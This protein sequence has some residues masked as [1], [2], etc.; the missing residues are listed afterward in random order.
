[1][2]GVDP[3][4]TD[5]STI[6][7]DQPLRDPLVELAFDV[8]PTPNPK[9]KGNCKYNG[10][11]YQFIPGRGVFIT[12]VHQSTG[13]KNKLQSNF[14]AYWDPFET[15]FIDGLGCNKC[16]D[17]VGTLQINKR[18]LL[19]ENPYYGGGN[20]PS[21]E[22]LLEVLPTLAEL[23]VNYTDWSQDGP[24]P[25]QGGPGTGSDAIGKTIDPTNM[26]SLP[27]TDDPVAPVWS[28]GVGTVDY[29]ADDF[30]FCVVCL[31]GIE[32]NAVYGCLQWGH[33]FNL[34]D[35]RLFG[36]TVDDYDVSRYITGIGSFKKHCDTN[37]RFPGYQ[38]TTV[39]K[40]FLPG[41]K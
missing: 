8:G 12:L 29:F 4:G 14:Q 40:G 27:H 26:S 5:I 15:K 36:Q 1:M 20:T 18:S 6:P 24:F 23:L 11:R 9:P 3:L 30:E 25:Y 37:A 10:Q 19:Y 35:H 21:P 33:E 16:C 41:V 28:P 22:L 39:M 31:S 17:E 7:T 2:R 32:K 38:P 34:R 13:R